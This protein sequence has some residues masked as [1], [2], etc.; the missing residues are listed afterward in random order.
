MSA[1]IST[2]TL[3]VW[4]YLASLLLSQEGLFVRKTCQSPVTES[5]GNRKLA[6]ICLSLSLQQNQ[7]FLMPFCFGTVPAL[8]VM[9]KGHPAA[10]FHRTKNERKEGNSSYV[11]L[12]GGGCSDRG[13]VFALSFLDI[14]S[15][16]LSQRGKAS[17]AAPLLVLFIPPQCSG[18]GCGHEYEVN[19]SSSDKAG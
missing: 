11:H 17:L 18:F 10:Q 14:N 4:N 12:T 1:F 16:V 3:V 2:L 7:L 9:W 13:M 6:S 5:Y 15:P 19:Q 8:E